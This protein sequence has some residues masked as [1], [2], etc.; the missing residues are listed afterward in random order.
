MSDGLLEMAKDYFQ[1]RI[2]PQAARIDRNPI[3]LQSALQ[4]MGDRCLLALR[5]PREWGGAGWEERTYR[6]FQILGARYSGALTFLQTQH[7]SAANQLATSSNQDLKKFYLPKM[8]RG[9]KLVGVGFSQLRRPGEPMMK[10]FPVTGG[11]QLCGQVPWVTGWG[12]FEDFIIG[13]TLPDGRSLYGL[14][15][16]QALPGLQCSPPMKLLSMSGT[17]TVS[18][19]I[20]DYFLSRDFIVSLQPADAIEASDQKNVLHHGFHALGCAWAGLDVI[21]GVY[22]QKGLESLKNAHQQLEKALLSC[23]EKMLNSHQASFADKLH[24]RGRAINLA[25]QCAQGTVIASGGAANIIDHPAGRV[26]RE[27]LQFSVSGQ[28][29]AVMENSL[30]QLLWLGGQCYD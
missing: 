27:A 24:W 20:Q 15:P 11:Y 3:A 16:L 5:V 10:A 28:T 30:G 19:T 23:Q 8:A 21:F 18:L 29:G 7:Q 1:N 25:L 13:A 14:L 26:Y 4:G 2:A 22:R 6:Q 17:N 12:F 9:E